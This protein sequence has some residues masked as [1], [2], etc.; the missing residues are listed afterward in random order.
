[1]IDP[2][3]KYLTFTPLVFTG[4]PVT[5]FVA[6]APYTL[7]ERESL[8]YFL[9]IY[10]PQNSQSPAFEKIT[11]LEGR[12]KPPA[13]PF[14][15][16]D[17]V[18]FLVNAGK[19]GLLD[20]ILASPK[21]AYQQSGIS[22]VSTLT[23][24]F[25]L[26]E[27]IQGGAPLQNTSVQRPVLWAYKGGL[28][29]FHHTAYSS[30]FFTQHLE[31]NRAFLTF[32][33]KKKFIGPAQEE[34][35]YF[36]L[37]FSPLPQEVRVRVLIT[38]QDGTQEL[39]TRQT[40]AR[41]I[42]NQVL[43]LPVGPGALSLHGVRSYKVWLSDQA[44]HRLSEIREFVVDYSTY[45][46]DSY[47]IFANSLGTFDTVRFTGQRLT[48]IRAEK[49]F[50]TAVDED[51]QTRVK[52]LSGS[53]T[54]EY[55]LN[56]GYIGRD[57]SAVT[58][59]LSEL[60]YSSEHY[61]VT[62]SGHLPVTLHQDEYVSGQSDPA[63]LIYHEFIF[64]DALVSESFS[65]L[66]AVTPAQTRPT[67]YLPIDLFY[68][69]RPDGY[70]SGHIK[71]ARLKQIYADT[72]EDVLP[73]RIKPNVE[74]DPDY[75]EPFYEESVAG[76]TPFPSAEINRPGTYKRQTCTGIT[77]PGY[78][79]IVIAEG[80]FGGET[81]DQANGLAEAEYH[82]TNTQ[83]YA[84]EY[85][86]CHEGPWIYEQEVPAGYAF[87]KINLVN[88]S[89]VANAISKWNDATTE[90]KGNGWFVWGPNQSPSDVYPSGKWDILLPTDWGTSKPW[91]FSIYSASSR[92]RI[93]VNGENI[94]DDN[95]PRESGGVAQIAIPHASIPSEA[96]VYIQ[97]D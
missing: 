10:A 62:A 67:S 55:I 57:V 63:E 97:I 41:L 96:K 80:A 33:P 51:F 76:T 46:T 5:H 72:L 23:T 87:F 19:N 85:G 77:V 86:V 69:L 18:T 9:D 3:K 91:R 73:L 64:Q 40:L 31:Q 44:D 1:M 60:V 82:R 34:Y 37:N 88:S 8:R 54:Q 7:S 30:V 49:E 4:N 89:Y 32:Q 42:T 6:P 94:Y 61:L 74:G 68:L 48:T 17:G 52:V 16:S 47:I 25:Y 22:V 53:I 11:T 24:P 81:A 79:T 58:N 65:V 66:P 92:V 45:V 2:L 26:T 35:L 14:D 75:I 71:G 27:K 83:Q 29:G 39:L 38:H 78:A 43:C 28:S 15:T 56:T 50:Y 21:P 59:Y 13:P 90:L 36:L 95:P 70:R 20:S 84:D 12:E 93:F